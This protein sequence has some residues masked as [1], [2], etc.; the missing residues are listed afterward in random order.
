MKTVE[1]LKAKHEKE[2]AYLLANNAVEASLEIPPDTVSSGDTKCPWIAYKVKTLR[3]AYDLADTFTR[4]EYAYANDGC[5]SYIKPIPLLNEDKVDVLLPIEDG[6]PYIELQNIDNH[7]HIAE[8]IFFIKLFDGRYG[9][10][11]IKIEQV[12]WYIGITVEHEGYKGRASGVR[13]LYPTLSEDKRVNWA[14]GG[15]KSARA[16]YHWFRRAEYDAFMLPLLNLQH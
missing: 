8:M 15:D 11:N 9:K 1:E 5:F 2:M 3:E 13:K 16:T 7:Y 14:S 4:E 6:T 10:V 12:P